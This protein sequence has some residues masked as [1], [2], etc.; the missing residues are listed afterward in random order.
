MLYYEHIEISVVGEVGNSGMLIFLS[1]NAK[2]DN[3]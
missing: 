3:R 1:N 2:W